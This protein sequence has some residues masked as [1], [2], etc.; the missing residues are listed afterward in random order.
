MQHKALF[1]DRD[2][3]INRD[4]GFVHRIADFELLPDVPEMLRLFRSRGYLLILV[5][6]QTGIGKGYYRQHDVEMVHAH[7]NRLLASEGVA[8]DEIYY[9]IHHPD[10]GRCLC[11]KP[12]PLFVEKALARFRIDPAR[13]FFIGDKERDVQ[14]GEAAGVRGILIPS[15]SSL[16]ALEKLIV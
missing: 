7:M 5:T 16:R 14:A 9:C 3:V 15:G 1:L 13:S 10:S 8:F 12:S 11:R 4:Q 2:G 6:N